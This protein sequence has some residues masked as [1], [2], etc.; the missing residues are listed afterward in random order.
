MDLSK[1]MNPLPAT[2]PAA[3]PATAPTI[4]PKKPTPPPPPTKTINKN[5]K[6]RQGKGS[7]QKKMTKYRGL[8]VG[9][10][11]QRCA[12]ALITNVMEEKKA[13]F[14]GARTELTTG[15]SD[16]REKSHMQYQTELV[17][18]L[19]EEE[20]EAEAKFKAQQKEQKARFK[21]HMAAVKQK[22]A[23]QYNVDMVQIFKGV[24][25][26]VFDELEKLKQQYISV[27]ETSDEEE[28]E[29]SPRPPVL[30]ARSPA[31]VPETQSPQSGPVTPKL[32][33]ANKPKRTRLAKKK[34]KAKNLPSQ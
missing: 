28:P 20:K 22:Y 16:L 23:M 34:G 26:G 13:I 29:S 11:F 15:M 25:T 33:E 30:A 2:A 1:V 18:A 9:K 21:A 4:L 12:E 32:P 27:E 3:I 6:K 24:E 31:T 19:E 17:A 14:A 8:N 5:K 7:R 10:H